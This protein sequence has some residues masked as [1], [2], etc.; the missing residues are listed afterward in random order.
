[1][2]FL[3]IMLLFTGLP[4][5]SN[6]RSCQLR[7]KPICQLKYSISILVLFVSEELPKGL[8]VA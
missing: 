7:I 5:N 3:K 4:V 1:M 2:D 8:E 6:A